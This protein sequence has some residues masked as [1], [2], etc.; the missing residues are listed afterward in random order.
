[1]LCLS[2]T[3]VGVLAS[4]ATAVDD[5]APC[6]QAVEDSCAEGKDGGFGV[7][8]GTGR[9]DNAGGVRSGPTRGQTPISTTYMESLHL[10]TCT[11]NGPGGADAVCAAALD[12]CELPTEVR[13]WVYTRQVNR[14]TG[15]ATD[16]AL[17]TDPPFVC[18]GADDPVLDP[19]VAIAAIIE[20]E[21]KRVVVLKGT[22]EVSPRPDTLVNIPTRFTTDAPASYDIPLT[23]L[24]Q[25][26]TI[27]ATARRWT[28][29]FGD[30]STATTTAA[31]TRARVEHTYRSAVDLGAYVVIEW[32]GTYRIGGGA[33]LPINGTA[34]T[35]GEPTALAVKEARTDLVHDSS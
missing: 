3:F 5:R 24:G 6:S 7:G 8:L 34:T 9:Q 4:S 21:F 22:A 28:W 20:S 29:H 30:G 11:G 35:V 27:T 33:V 13:Y 15:Q 31:G 18:L 25:P 1:M 2:V 12:T 14:Q 16:W 10:P 32:S 26:V 23:L 19:A 17:V